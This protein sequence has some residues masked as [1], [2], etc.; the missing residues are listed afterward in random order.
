[1]S[2]IIGIENNVEGRTQA[3]VLGHPGCYVYGRDEQSSIAAVPKAISEYSDWIQFHAGESWLDVEKVEFVL[4]DTWDVYDIDEN[5]D[6]VEAGY[7]VNAWFQHDWKPLKDVEIARGL[8]IL[9]WSRRELL[10]VVKGLPPEVMHARYSNERWSIDGILSHVGGAEW[11]YLD[12]LDRAPPSGTLPEDPFERLEFVR[13]HFLEVL[14]S[15]TGQSQVVGIDGEIWSPR[16]LLRRAVWHER[17][18]TQHI[19]KL[20]N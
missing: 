4:D 10:Q 20:L 11:W 15:F 2:Y 7:S 6:R 12:R 18:H 5:Y 13:S 8:K 14:P 9:D 3:W 17:D 1:M 16:K 19:H